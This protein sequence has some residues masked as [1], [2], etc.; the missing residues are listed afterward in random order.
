MPRENS[1]I[2]KLGAGEVGEFWSLPIWGDVGG[3]RTEHSRRQSRFVSHVC[4]AAKHRS[5]S[6]VKESLSHRNYGIPRVTRA[7]GKRGNPYPDYP[8]P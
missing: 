2:Q 5:G 6:D 8:D 7:S 4:S 1:C 3:V